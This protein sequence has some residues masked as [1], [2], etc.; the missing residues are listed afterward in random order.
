M[1]VY[2]IQSG[3][4]GLVSG[5]QQ[6]KSDMVLAAEP[7][8]LFAPEARKGRLYIVAEA[9]QE[10][11]RSHDACQL[12]IATIRKAFYNDQSYSVTSSLRKAI[13]AANKVLYEQNFNTASA[14]RA[15]I[16]VSCIVIK[17]HDVYVAQAQP[18]QAYL[19]TDGKLRAMPMHPSWN[20]G[21]DGATAL[22]MP[23]AI[24]SSLTIE[25]EFYRAVLHPG[26]TIVACSSNLARMLGR[27][28][29]QNLLRAINP[30]EIAEH[31]IDVCKQNALPE[32]HG[33]IVSAR[34]RLSTAAQ[35]APL[36]RSGMSERGR[37]LVQDIGN[38]VGR[39]TGEVVLMVRPDQRDKQRK[40]EIRQA[41][42]QR[43]QAQLAQVPDEP[44]PMPAP[45][46]MPL[47]LG[48]PLDERVEQERRERQPQRAPLGR[49][50][51]RPIDEAL[52]P[53]VLLGEGEYGQVMPPPPR[54]R[55]VDLSDTPGMG[56]PRTR[57]QPADD[58]SLPLAPTMGEQLLRPFEKVS[59][60]LT[61]YGRR[62]RLRRPPPSAMP[63]VRRRPG[64]SYRREGPPFPWLLLLLLVLSVA[65]L[66]VYGKSL[67][68][69][70]ARQEATR[71]L[72]QAEAAV[73][74]V[75]AAPDD[76][77]AQAQLDKAAEALAL[78][79]A[80]GVVTSTAE[81]Q[82]QYQSL[83]R[84]YD[85][86]LA[87]IQKISYLDDITE[88][89]RHPQA[90]AG[91]TFNSIVVPPAPNGITNTVGFDSIYALDANQGVLYRMPKQGGVPEPYLTPDTPA[92]NLGGAPAGQ[93]RAIAWRTD[94][95]V[96]VTQ[97]PNNTFLYAFRNGNDWNFSNLGGS[98]E[99]RPPDGN[100]L[101][102]A[103]YEGN[104]YFLNAITGQVLKYI[105][106]RPAD[107]YTPWITDFG[108]SNAE[109]AIDLAVDGKVYLLQPDGRV[110]VYAVN[111]FEREIA[112]P[113]LKP[114]IAVVTSFFVT[115]ASPD[116]GSIFLVDTQQE[117]IVQLDKRT[118]NLIQQ[119]KVRSDSQIRLNTLTAV[120]LD[121]SVPQPVLYLANGGQIL[122][123]TLPSPP[124][125]IRQPNPQPTAGAESAPTAAPAAAP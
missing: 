19:L 84:Q 18:A 54:E 35:A 79:R 89:A 49:P 108:Q 21:Q 47:D 86:A 96:A 62:R 29:M 113:A 33:V 77:S 97:N 23:G 105:S 90:S 83:Q 67:M 92:T 66:V 88:V 106:G 4:F 87:A 46:P 110:D 7:G 27:E 122:K 41:H 123:A 109:T 34:A 98:E 94:N 44:P 28:Q 38:W 3:Q 15:Y 12:V 125:S 64:L 11:P 45:V 68:D 72:Q 102:L 70:Q 24:G 112:P 95:I 57:A 120:Y 56:A 85:L 107:L 61:D 22:L 17:D 40:A 53:S 37:M 115:G 118:G 111:A 116:E 65:L 78:V 100:H 63:K 104:L 14:K 51:P 91:S 48:E 6:A 99:W 16:G 42:S 50:Q 81:N 39:M 8:A 43:E 1:S 26:D 119:I 10:A 59:G 31:L 25:P 36:S 30:D 60:A 121:E 82:Q 52:P 13:A 20:D 73:A 103:T 74:Q 32:A 5:I 71:L 2:E 114:P 124:R 93:T 80:N 55:R 58:R 75:S 9:S 101:R 69:R 76:A 117:R